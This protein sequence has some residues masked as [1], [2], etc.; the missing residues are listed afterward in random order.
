MLFSNKHSVGGVLIQARKSILNQIFHIYEQ[1][2]E[3]AHAMTK[4]NNLLGE[5]LLEF[6]HVITEPQI[7]VT[8]D[9]NADGIMVVSAKECNS[10]AMKG[11][12]I[13]GNQQHQEMSIVNGFD[14]E[15]RAKCALVF[16]RNL[17]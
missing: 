1:V 9:I 6:A 3:G 17:H 13:G 11:I 5:F 12:V 7:L 8:F 15:M 10:G 16:G 14:V 2:F 4:E